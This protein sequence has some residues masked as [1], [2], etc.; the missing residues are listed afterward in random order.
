[1][2]QQENSG[3]KEV[4]HCFVVGE[5]AAD[6][7]SNWKVLTEIKSVI[8]QERNVDGGSLAVSDFAKRCLKYMAMGL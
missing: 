8:L 3:K 7:V 2:K 4:C 5:L 6:S 1:M